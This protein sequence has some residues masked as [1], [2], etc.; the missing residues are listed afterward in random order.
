[1]DGGAWWTIDKTIYTLHILYMYN[2]LIAYK[3]I[4]CTCVFALC[5]C[6]Y[7]YTYIDVSLKFNPCMVL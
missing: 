2:F 1:M 4:M 3:H 6:V 5:V 7:V